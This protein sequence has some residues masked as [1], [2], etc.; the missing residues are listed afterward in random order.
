MHYFIYK[1]NDLYCEEVRVEDIV[2]DVGSP[3][4]V[5]SQRTLIEHFRKLKVAFKPVNPLICYSM[6]ANSNLA[7][8]K[9]LVNEGAGLD[10]VSGGELYRALKVKADP[11][12]IVFAGVGKTD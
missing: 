4:Y 12:K 8:C 1:D 11:E 6:K 2:K 7:I 9:A 3:C 10:I 5:Y